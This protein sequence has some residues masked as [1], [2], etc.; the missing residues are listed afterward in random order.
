MSFEAVAKNFT[1]HYYGMFDNNKRAELGVLYQPTSML[2]WEGE[3]IQGAE[4]NRPKT[5]GS[6]I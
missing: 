1:A 6:T 5:A 3:Q 2:T 4:K